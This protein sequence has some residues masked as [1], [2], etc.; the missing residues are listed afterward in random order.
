M[1]ILFLSMFG[2]LR[3]ALRPRDC[4]DP[5]RG[6]IGTRPFFMPVFML[7]D[8]E[9]GAFSPGFGCLRHQISSKLGCGRLDM[10]G[11]GTRPSQAHTDILALCTKDVPWNR[12]HL[13]RLSG[14]YYG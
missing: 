5:L 4:F 2:I 7:L 1:T 14:N 9:E 11:E 3:E 13:A 8:F 6:L 10:E 12:D